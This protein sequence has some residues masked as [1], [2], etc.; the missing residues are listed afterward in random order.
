MSCRGPDSA[1]AVLDT[2]GHVAGG[3][4]IAF[5][6]VPDTPISY[7]ADAAAEPEP[8]GGDTK[9]K[10]LVKLARAKLTQPI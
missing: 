2:A 1:A 5:V 8:T 3:E 10:K 4:S 9:A 7:P 6:I